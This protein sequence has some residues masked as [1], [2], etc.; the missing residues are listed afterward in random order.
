MK[1]H[2]AGPIIGGLV[3][4]V[5]AGVLLMFMIQ[6]DTPETIYLGI[7]LTMFV[8]VPLLIVN[9]VLT[10]VYLWRKAPPRTYAMMWLPPMLAM[11][12]LPI[13]EGVYRMQQEAFYRAHPSIR[14]VHVNLSGHSLWLDPDAA[15]QSSGGSGELAGDRPEQFL[16]LTRYAGIDKMTAYAAARLADDF[17][18]IR[19][20]RS[21][22]GETPFTE[23]P[24]NRP[25]PFPPVD[26]FLNRLSFKGGE[27]SVIEYWYYHYADHVDVV[28]AINLSG[29]QGMDLWGSGLPVVDF[30]LANLGALPIVRL[31]IDG[32][33]I[34]L[35]E[36]AFFPEGSE[37]ANCSSRNYSAYAINRLEKPLK[38]R[39]QLAEV[40]PAWHEASVPVSVFGPAPAKGSIRSTSVDLY[41]QKDGSVVAE[42]SQLIDMP[43]E[44][45]A[46]RVHSASLPLLQVP[47]CGRA[48]ERYSEWVEIIRE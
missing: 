13:S 38:V 37:K 27:A 24:V 12:I 7:A 14:E 8:V 48:T 32:Q 36:Q 30:H 16:P 28:P 39:W 33:A 11:A 19:I 17:R 46:L 20:F 1:P 41:F 31:E 9:I 2:I 18:E 45:L 3:A 26:I 40:N 21:H 29:S 4:L 44:K 43:G 25:T 5:V 23:L 15:G 10:G 22:P 6:R 42:A 34:A 47:P 35:G